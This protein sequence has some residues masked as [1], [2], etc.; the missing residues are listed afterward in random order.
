MGFRLTG[1]A[2]FLNSGVP[3]VAQAGM[4]HSLVKDL[5]YYW[6]EKNPKSVYLKYLE[7]NKQED[8]KN[9]RVSFIKSTCTYT[10]L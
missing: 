6:G 10:H 2:G 7:L 8:H 3:V 5:V 4:S 9:Q 1:V